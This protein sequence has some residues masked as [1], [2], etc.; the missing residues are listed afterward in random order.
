M[1]RACPPQ[2][3]STPR[4]LSLI[5]ASK[6]SRGKGKAPEP[7]SA[8]NSGAEITVPDSRAASSLSKAMTRLA[9]IPAAAFGLLTP[10]MAGVGMSA[11]SALVV[12]NALR[13]QRGARQGQ[14]QPQSQQ[15]NQ[16]QQQQQ[17]A[18]PA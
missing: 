3:A 8:P 2:E 6:L 16:Q 14:P 11:S 17:Q 13:L 12:L 4:P 10:W 7:A 5:T 15:Q 9:A 1:S 18:G